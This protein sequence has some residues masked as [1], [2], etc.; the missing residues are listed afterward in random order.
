MSSN[1]N[2]I[3]L[4]IAG[5]QVIVDG[6]RGSYVVVFLTKKYPYLS[7]DF[8]GNIMGHKSVLSYLLVDSDTVVEIVRMVAHKF[9]NG[10]V[11]YVSAISVK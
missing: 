2:Q 5:T 1:F 10:D 11:V 3:S 6:K 4:A 8:A 9:V 7:S